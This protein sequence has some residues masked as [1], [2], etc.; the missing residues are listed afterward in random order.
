MKIKFDGR[1]LQPTE[2]VI[3]LNGVLHAKYLLALN[4]I[5]MIE[6]NIEKNN[7]LKFVFDAR[8]QKNY[9]NDTETEKTKEINETGLAEGINLYPKDFSAVYFTSLQYIFST[10]I[11]TQ[12]DDTLLFYPY[13][14][15]EE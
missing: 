4:K 11:I 14:S 1:E 7:A 15:C 9:N 10:E 3:Y 12:N 8:K 2:V 6:L 5:S 13:A